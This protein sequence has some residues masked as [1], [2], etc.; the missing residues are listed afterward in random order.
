[1]LID[2]PFQNIEEVTEYLSRDKIQCLVCGK[3]Y[4]L[5][6]KHLSDAHS[7]STGE[8][9]ARFGIPL[10]RELAGVQLRAKVR[11]KLAQYS[12]SD[13]LK[14]LAMSAEPFQTMDDV[15]EY[16]SGT[17]I[18]CLVCGKRFHCLTHQHLQ[19]HGLSLDEYRVKFGIPYRRSLTSADLRDRFRAR[20]TPESIEILLDA[21]ARHFD[22]A[23]RGRVRDA[24]GAAET[25]GRHRSLE[26]ERS[27]DS[28]HI[29]NPG[30]NQVRRLRL[31]LC[32]DFGSLQT[33]D[34]LHELR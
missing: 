10:D 12:T 13:R 18:E 31:R 23:P 24:A 33:A 9:R 14:T 7:L 25:A 11:R 17:R 16:L 27:R 3:H 15:N 20:V 26:E 28:T 32:N 19:L 8:Y 1:M 2:A 6:N 4:N 34:T 30:Y 22:V 29:A 21:R 5:L